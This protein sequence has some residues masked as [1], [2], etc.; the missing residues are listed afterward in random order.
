MTKRL[1]GTG[2]SG[3]PD[4]SLRTCRQLLQARPGGWRQSGAIGELYSLLHRA[5]GAGTPGMHYTPPLATRFLVSRLADRPGLSWLDPACG[6]GAF[7]EEIQRQ[8]PGAT[9]VVGADLDRHALALARLIGDATPA[10]TPW[11]L[12]HCNTLAP[13][14]SLPDRLRDGVDRIVMNPP[15]RNGVEEGGLGREERLTLRERFLTA[16]GPFDLYI[17]FVERALQL[18]KPDGRMGL[19]LPDKWLA[20]SYGQA[21]RELLARETRISE[22]HHAP[23]SRLFGTADVEPV[24]LLLERR[25]TQAPARVGRLDAALRS[26]PTHSVSQNEFRENANAGWGPLLHSGRS[27]WIQTNARPRL[28]DR[29][30]VKASMT[31]AEFYSVRVGEHAANSLPPVALLSSGAIEP[32]YHDWGVR[33]QR[34]RGQDLLRPA[35]DPGELSSVRRNQLARPRVL[36]ANMSRRLEALPVC[37]ESLM[38]VV[39]VIQIFCADEQ[40]CLMLAAWLNSGPLND[41]LGLWYDPLRLSGQLSLNRRLVASLP[42]PPSAGPCRNRLLESGI[43]LRELHRKPPGRSAAYTHVAQ[44]ELDAC[45]RQELGLLRMSSARPTTHSAGVESCR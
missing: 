14:D 36:V 13:L 3:E 27:G 24:L 18:L 37:G 28:G 20:A 19:L 2:G 12:F 32:W 22:L 35:I 44:A 11:E 25:R 26:G 34:F 29:F 15:Y 6:C 21:L 39:N 9:R 43:R 40:E 23:R 33:A 7:L 38:G 1:P 17:P 10:A 16:R 42:A 45:V 8:D 31:T 5:D 30:E 4:E 41:W